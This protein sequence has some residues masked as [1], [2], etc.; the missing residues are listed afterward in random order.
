[1]LSADGKVVAMSTAR[2]DDLRERVTE[3]MGK[4]H[5]AYLTSMGAT[6]NGLGKVMFG[7]APTAHCFLV[8]GAKLDAMRQAEKAKPGAPERI[9]ANDV[10]TSC[11]GKTCGSK[12]LIMACD[13]RGR[14]EGTKVEDAG[15]YHAGLLL[16]ETGYGEPA[17]MISRS[18]FGRGKQ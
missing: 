15:Q 5:Y 2:R 14:I 18:R 17:T 3:Y 7:K 16:D 12:L 4:K 8:D 9:S 10:L 11:F 13:F 1:M 6:F